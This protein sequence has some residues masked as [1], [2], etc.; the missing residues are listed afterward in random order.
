MAKHCSV[1]NQTYSEAL[2]ACPHCAAA[3]VPRVPPG[4]ESEINLDA[5]LLVG[6]QPSDAAEN[7]SVV[8]LG[9]KGPA[10][11]YV[12]PQGSESV[13]HVEPPSGTRVPDTNSGVAVHRAE[14]P[15]DSSVVQWADLVQDAGPVDPSGVRV[16]SPSDKDLLASAA[17]E[18]DSSSHVD[19]APAGKSDEPSGLQIVAKSEADVIVEG[20]SD[21]KI[22]PKRPETPPPEGSGVRIMALSE[23]DVVPAGSGSQPDVLP[24]TPAGDESS[25]VNLGELPRKKAVSDL[26]LASDA[27]ESGASGAAQ[28][29][30]DAARGDSVEALVELPED[31]GTSKGPDGESPPSGSGT[32]QSGLDLA[33][34]TGSDQGSSILPE[35]P[36]RPPSHAEKPVRKASPTEPILHE[37][38]PDKP[39][40]RGLPTQ[41]AFYEHF[42]DAEDESAVNLGALPQRPPEEE[43]V[44]ASSRASALEEAGVEEVSS[45]KT[46]MDGG[47]TKAT[48]ALHSGS[49]VKILA[50]AALGL[51]LGIG[52]SAAYVSLFGGDSGKA[53]VNTPANNTNP[54]RVAAANQGGNEWVARF[55][56]KGPDDVAKM[57]EDLDGAKKEAEKNA[58]AQADLVKAEQAKSSTLNND[59]KTAA[60]KATE[61]AEKATAAEKKAADVAADLEKTKQAETA[62]RKQAEESAASIKELNT[63]LADAQKDGLAGAKEIEKLKSRLEDADT[64]QAATEKQVAVAIEARKQAES[65]LDAAA[66]K[67]KDGKYLKA[68]ATGAD[69]ARAVEQVI[70][71]AKSADPSGKLA[72]VQAELASAQAKLAQS[73]VA[74][75][76]RRTP[77][78]MLDIWLVALQQPTT[79]PAMAKLALADV[80]RVARDTK[81]GAA[82]QAKAACVKG[83]ALRQQGNKEEAKTVLA[84]AIK[85]APAEAEWLAAARS[86]IE[87]KPRPITAPSAEVLEGNPLL[88]EAAY[89][90]GVQQY[91][92]GAHDR[93]EEQFLSAIRNDGRDARYHYYLGLALLSQQKRSAAQ[94]E[95]QRGA[96]L[97]RQ[98]RPSRAAVNAALER[99]QGSM[100]QSVERYRR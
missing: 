15:S 41:P 82:I 33:L 21:S 81:A 18:S 54:N 14:D 73:D 7:S 62:A 87:D 5:H 94:Q 89:M 34:L 27:L 2:P 12:P 74:L 8:N 40:R 78:A 75:A 6:E 90:A 35:R 71:A 30:E 20:D 56:D 32:E 10:T 45:I 53:S 36:R 91:W 1:C 68:D 55:P 43:E 39:V 95:F 60:G 31:S 98:G 48:G 28:D 96:E 67:L 64:K 86:A 61:Q 100:R 23:P 93:A 19:I 77:Q 42:S 29:R 97:E 13:I 99:I 11:H 26:M 65:V 80:E 92:S 58:A 69:V 16:D 59:L 37:Q 50:G 47:S 25:M 22:H 4:S 76:E 79:D 49:L 38:S 3:R 70:A 24:P 66:K 52:G 88:A 85:N 44:P 9:K 63:K 84:E 51:I 17:G 46:R 83:L 72:T 57:I